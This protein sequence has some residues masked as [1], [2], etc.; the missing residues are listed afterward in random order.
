M[1]V[2]P[3]I[4]LHA[5]ISTSLFGVSGDADSFSSAVYNPVHLL[6][7]RASPQTACCMLANRLLVLRLFYGKET[8]LPPLSFAFF[9]TTFPSK[10]ALRRLCT[11]CV[12]P[13]QSHN[14]LINLPGIC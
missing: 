4:F 11:L 7:V 8:Q 13:P 3:R 6:L 10:T 2:L 9:F 12:F 5:V 14:S 1:T